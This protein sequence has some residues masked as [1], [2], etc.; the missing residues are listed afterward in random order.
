MVTKRQMLVA[1]LL[2]RVPR[3]AVV[4]AAYLVTVGEVVVKGPQV[5]DA[6][7]T[8]LESLFGEKFW[9]SLCRDD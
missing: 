1:K 8:G 5:A 4:T 3:W 2:R 6:Q 7:V 9:Q